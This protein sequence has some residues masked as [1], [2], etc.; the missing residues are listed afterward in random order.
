MSLHGIDKKKKTKK[1][2][3]KANVLL[4]EHLAHAMYNIVIFVYMWMFE[5]KLDKIVNWSAPY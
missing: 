3:K 1:E 5:F 2:K 4:Y